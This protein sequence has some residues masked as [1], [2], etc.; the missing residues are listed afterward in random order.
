MSLMMRICWF[1]HRCS[2]FKWTGGNYVPLAQSDNCPKY[3]RHSG[4]IRV[5]D[6]SITPLECF[7]LFYTEQIFQDLVDFANENARRRK[8]SD[9][10]NNQ[11]DWKMLMVDELKAYYG[12][13]IT[14]DIIKLDRDTHYWHQ[15]GKHF[16][17]YTRFGNVMSRNS[18]FQIH[19]YLYSVNTADKLHKIQYILNSVRHNFQDEYVPHEHVTVDEAMMPFKGLL[20]FKQFMK[21]KPLKSGIKLWVSADAVTAYCYNLA[22]YTANMDSRST[23]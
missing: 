17:L 7:K 22:V 5:L 14:K 4:P 3:S 12:L 23:D 11:G 10:D 18:V 2:W 13:V 19:Q 6:A 9:P 15:G 21:D 8:E 20:G 16:L 1:Y